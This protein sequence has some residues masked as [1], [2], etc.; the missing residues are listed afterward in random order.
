MDAND[1]DNEESEG[2]EENGRENIYYV[3]EN[4]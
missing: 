3:S 1:S 2:N 4:T